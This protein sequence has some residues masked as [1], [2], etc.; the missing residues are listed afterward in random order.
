MASRYWRCRRVS[1]GEVCGTLNLATKKKCHLCGKLRPKRKQPAHRAVLSEM[2]Y[3]AWVE[4]YGEVCGICGKAP[5]AGR[6]LHRDHDHR[7]GR[8]RGLLCF[9]CNTAL[10]SY[11]TLEW[12]RAAVA[13]LE[14]VEE[15]VVA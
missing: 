7:S 11:M 1:A 10:R 5:K 4:A 8:A 13:Y 14:R 9:R 6:R 3:E 15:R 2:P 12:M